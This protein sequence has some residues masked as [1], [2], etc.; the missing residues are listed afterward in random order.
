MYVIDL[1]RAIGLNGGSNGDGTGGPDSGRRRELTRLV[2]LQLA[3]NG[4]PTAV[5][6]AAPGGRNGDDAAVARGLL[7]NYREKTRLLEDYRCPADRRIEA[8]LAQHLADLDLP[9][10]LRLPGTTLVLDRHGLAR[11]LSLPAGGDEYVGPLVSSYR[12]RNGVLHNPKSDRRTTAGTFH[13]AEGGLPIPFDKKAVPKRVFAELFR[14]AMHPPE[15][16]LR[17]PFYGGAADA[18]PQAAA[19]VSLMLRPI[20]SPEV[21]GVCPVRTM[22]TRFFAPG[23]LVGNLDFVESIFGNAGDPF[24]PENDAGLDVEHW[25][26]HTGCVVLATH[27]VDATKKEL[28]LPHES[29]ATQRQKRDGMCWK[30]EREKYNDG[31]AF[32][33]TCRTDAGVIITLIADSYY[34]YCKKEVKTQLSYA[35]NLYG[36]VEEEHAGGAIAFPSYALGDEFQAISQ[37]LNGRTFADVARDY[38]QWVDVRPEG[39]GVDKVRPDLLYVPEDA[40]FSVP[41]HRIT[42]KSGGKEQSIPLLAGK[43]YMTPSGYKVRVERHP[44]APS[45]RLIGTVGD[46]T[47]CHK[48]CTVSGGGKSEISKSITDYMLYGP[49]FV[50]DIQKDLDRVQ[51]IFAR[52]YSTR[53][54]KDGNVK[55]DY[56][57]DASRPILSPKRSL[58]SV[59]KLLTPS[60]EYTDEYNQWLASIP[61]HIYP[62][63][64]IIKRFQRP[65]W[66]AEDPQGADWRKWFGVDIVNG[67]PGN[68]LKFGKRKLVGTYLRV[69][70]LGDRDWRTF[71]V[72]QDFAAAAKVQVEDDITASVVV[73]GRQLSGLR[74]GD[75]RDVSYKFVTN[76]EYRLFQR[77]DDAVHRGLDKQTELDLSRPDNFISNFEPLRRE[78]A[79]ALVERA[80]EF[81]QFTAPMQKLLREAAQDG[82]FCDASATDDS[83]PARDAGKPRGGAGPRFVVSSAHPRI[84]DGKPTKNPRYLQLRPDLDRPLDRYVAERGVR[85]FRA[86][87]ADKPVHQPVDAVLMGRRNNPPDAAAGIRALAVYNPI[88]YQELPELFMDYVCSLTGKS[89]STTG[90]GSEGALTKG[91][92]NAVRPAADLNNALVSFILTG[93]AGFS[94]AAG[95]IGPRVRVDHDVSLLVPEIWCRLAPRE[96]DPAYLIGEGYLEPVKDFEHGGETIHASRLGYRI[97][98]AFVRAFFGRVFDNPSKVFDEAILKPETQDPACFADGVKNIC[99]AQ[100]RV[101]RQYFEDGS[102]RELCPPLRVLMSILAFGSHDGM[103]AHD[104]EVRKL[105]TRDAL[106][107]SDWYRQRLQTKQRRDAALWGRHREYLMAFLA[108]PTYADEAKRLGIE[109]RLRLAEAELKKVSEP[110]YLGELAGTIG[111]HPF[112]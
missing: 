63:V 87:P 91:P 82:A 30:D 50:A 86:I 38:G 9:E 56:G 33:V 49:I 92:F 16:V 100:Q 4:L 48:P 57:K 69:G 89:P 51:E 55:P 83:G 39:Y 96:R 80:A 37:R 112:S 79:Q 32:K 2:N 109:G 59:I 74:A 108:R 97:T 35:A 29:R 106:L 99:E 75:A 53:W 22:E 23:S 85:L 76:C 34:G 20:V 103:T 43:V 3:A 72:R 58:G 107:A 64:F 11:E 28:G 95:H 110:A 52:D 14:R 61:S 70:L 54:K 15:E 18:K 68:E 66:A 111:A 46:G 77:P 93:L 90:A 78:D 8:F 17:L 40:F 81:D 10:P 42:W 84:V 67:S 31:K 19:F 41:A 62:V 24:L 13:V 5:A 26:G 71:K 98:D 73:P 25:T 105:F 27:L 65:E 44:G 36:S 88:H 21:P 104:P 45:W 12:L 102:V 60:A 101:A 7:A 94:T 47:L 1:Q 6:A